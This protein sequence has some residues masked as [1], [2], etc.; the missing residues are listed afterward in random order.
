MEEVP[1]Q[2]LEDRFEA[3]V[4]ENTGQQYREL[5]S[6]E[7]TWMESIGNHHVFEYSAGAGLHANYAAALISDLSPFN[8]FQTFVDNEIIGDIVDQKTLV[9]NQT[10]S[11]DY[12]R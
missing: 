5:E 11:T 4:D 6:E 2:E 3:E 12:N 9:R 1:E 7:H 10:L 8:C